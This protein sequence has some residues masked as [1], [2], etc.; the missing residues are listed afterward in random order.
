MG[1]IKHSVVCIMWAVFFCLHPRTLYR[2]CAVILA[3]AM[4]EIKSKFMNWEDREKRQKWNRHKRPGSSSTHKGARRYCP[5][6]LWLRSSGQIQFMPGQWVPSKSFSAQGNIKIRLFKK[7][8]AIFFWKEVKYKQKQ[9]KKTCSR[10]I[11]PWH[12]L[13]FRRSGNFI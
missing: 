10:H 7:S 8:K 9:N 3:I 12:W 13:A 4:G 5:W 2:R 11:G 6:H 1:W